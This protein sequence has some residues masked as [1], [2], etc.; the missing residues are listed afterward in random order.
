MY[1]CSEVMTIGTG[2]RTSFSLLYQTKIRVRKWGKTGICVIIRDNGTYSGDWHGFTLHLSQLGNRRWSR[3]FYQFYSNPLWNNWSWEWLG[4]FHFLPSSLCI[5][6]WKQTTMP[7]YSVENSMPSHR[8]Y[9]GQFWQY[10]MSQSN[11]LQS[12]IFLKACKIEIK[13]NNNF[14]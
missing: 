3:L 13:T 10:K 12:M 14:N 5:I 4:L 11:I 1:S 9:V 2:L 7:R 6:Q 8:F